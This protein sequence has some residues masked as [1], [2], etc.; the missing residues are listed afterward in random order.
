MENKLKDTLVFIVN[1]KP[2]SGKTYL[3]DEFIKKLLA[4]IFSK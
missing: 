1:G 2:E 4:E 3:C